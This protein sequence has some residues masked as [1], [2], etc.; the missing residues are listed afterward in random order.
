MLDEEADLLPGWPAGAGFATPAIAQ[1]DAERGDEQFPASL[2]ALKS[3]K[4]NGWKPDKG[5]TNPY[6]SRANYVAGPNGAEPMTV[7]IKSMDCRPRPDYQYRWWLLG[8]RNAA[9]KTIVPEGYR[10]MYAI[11]PTVAIVQRLDKSWA[12]YEGGK[13]RALPI[14]PMS[15]HPTDARGPCTEILSNPDGTQGVL[16]YGPVQNGVRDVAYFH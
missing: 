15:V 8:M 6:K 14:Q 1:R 11:S 3:E 13:E 16:V 7:T 9:G 2:A 5:W 10:N 4:C 12:I